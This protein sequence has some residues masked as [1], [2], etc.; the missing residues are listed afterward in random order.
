MKPGCCC[1]DRYWS[2]TRVDAVLLQW[3]QRRRGGG[4]S[5]SLWMI[6]LVVVLG[7]R[8]MNGRAFAIVGLLVRIGVMRVW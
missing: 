5:I 1:W 4:L 2:R 8:A 6:E 7:M 3:E